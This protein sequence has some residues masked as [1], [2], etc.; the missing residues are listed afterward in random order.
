[1]MLSKS[2]AAS[3]VGPSSVRSRNRVESIRRAALRARVRIGFVAM[4]SSGTLR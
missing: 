4:T 1:M 2:V 3:S